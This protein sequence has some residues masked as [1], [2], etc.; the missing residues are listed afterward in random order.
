MRRKSLCSLLAFQSSVCGPIRRGDPAQPFSPSS[1][2]EPATSRGDLREESAPRVS[3]IIP[4]HNRRE[5]LLRLLSSLEAST[6][7]ARDREVIV[8]TDCCSDGS[9]QAV[10]E[11]FPSTVLIDSGTMA[12]HCGRARELG[13]NAAKGTYLFFVDD[14]NL[15]DRDCLAALLRLIGRDQIGVLG[16]LMMNYPDGNGVWCAGAR[17]GRLGLFDYRRRDPLPV[18]K[19]DPELLEP[20][21]YLPNAWM[22]KASLLRE[23]VPFDAR[24]FPTAGFEV[25][26]ALRVMRAGFQVRVAPAAKVWHDCGYRTLSLRLLNSERVEMQA[27]ARIRIRRRFPEVFG[28]PLSFWLVFFPTTTAYHLARFAKEGE[29]LAWTVAYCRGSWRGVREALPDEP[30]TQTLSDVKGI[31]GIRKRATRLQFR[32]RR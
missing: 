13:A 26:F 21:H 27:L 24:T 19:D 11:Q 3:I 28:S 12:L 7:P 14:D 2:P 16:P 18:D 22:V 10:R 5:K 6:L 4:T 17:I 32:D 20:C 9:Q 15:V 31:E 29:F 8:V 23:L 1:R 25:D 30:S